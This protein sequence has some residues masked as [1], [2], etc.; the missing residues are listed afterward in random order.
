MDILSSHL[1]IDQEIIDELRIAI[2][3]RAPARR[4]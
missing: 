1:W 3:T 2:F 4:Q